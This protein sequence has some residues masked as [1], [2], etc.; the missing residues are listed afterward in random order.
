ME[1]DTA[2][3]KLIEKFKRHVPKVEEVFTCS[4]TSIEI[5]DNGTYFFCVDGQR[6][7]WAHS[8]AR[9][10]DG[11]TIDT[12]LAKRIKAGSQVSEDPL[13]KGLLITAE[14]EENK[15]HLAQKL[16]IYE[17]RQTL[18]VQIVLTDQTKLT[19]T[20]YLAPFDTPYPDKSGNPLFLSLDQKMLLVPY[21]N[22]MWVRYESTPPRP[23]RKSYDVTAIYNDKTR[24]GLLIGALDFNVWK[25]AIMWSAYDARSVLAFCGVSDATTHDLLP[26]GIVKGESVSSSRFV[27]GWYDDIRDGMED[28]GRMCE[29]VQPK[30]PWHGKSI[31]GWN[32]FSG[33]AMNLRLS[34]WKEAADFM[35]NELTEYHD[36][37][38]VTYPNLDGAFGLNNEK[39]KKYVK[40]F[41]DRGQQAGWYAAPLACFALIEG[42]PLKGSS[43][44]MKTIY[45][46]DEHGNRLPKI[47]SSIP[48]DPTHPL[49]EKHVR[50]T[51]K[52]LVDLGVD[53]IKLDFL[54]HGGVEGKFYNSEIT[55]GRMA[56]DYAYRIIE[57]ELSPEKTGREIFVSL[58]IAPLFP[59]F[60]G[61]ARRCCCDAFGHQEDVRYVL[62]ALNY[63][64][65]TNGTLYCFN[66][67]DH[68]TLYNSVVDGRGPTN[69]EEARSRYNSA[70]ISGTLMMLSDN[71]GP[72]GDE[73]I[74][75]N[76]R[77]RALKIANNPK[78]NE[79]ARFG[80]AFRPVE[81]NDVVTPF[82]TLEHAGR[83]FLAMFNFESEK[84]NLT[85][86]ASRAGLPESG[87]AVDLNRGNKVQYDKAVTY[88]LAPYDSVIFEILKS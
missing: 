42:L 79:V 5:L 51:L 19:E 69:E 74:I 1:K 84:T 54:S 64:W 56:L 11:R 47:D 86:D 49:W 44:P 38:G 3:K 37:D 16:M 33:L 73:E 6:I 8:S 75:K 61:T 15:L 2:K 10:V 50:A 81:L 53:Y 78:V 14:Y 72:E 57:D 13:G 36:G 46:K 43:K 76:S 77:E 24:E 9:T 17:E 29:V 48:L 67:P 60:L 70:V 52:E 31:F 7:N 23:G 41:H 39:I 21:D 45:L 83:Y 59:Y 80:K 71:Y 27:V 28:Y 88:E 87:T 65:W 35:Q 30:R 82:Y 22:D 55:T 12:R 34:H 26:H 20:R 32:S 66:D 85:V 4:R 68:V 40:E 62:N 25:N 18:C 58:S 63:A